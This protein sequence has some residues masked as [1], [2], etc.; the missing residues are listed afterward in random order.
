MRP[1]YVLYKQRLKPVGQLETCWAAW[2]L[3]SGVSATV[4]NKHYAETII[5]LMQAG[6]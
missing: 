6:F 4:E 1:I 3:V 5:S 2:L